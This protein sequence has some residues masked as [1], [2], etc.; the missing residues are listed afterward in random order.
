M[1]HLEAELDGT[2]QGIMHSATSTSPARALGYTVLASSTSQP[3]PAG[4]LWIQLG[5][6]GSD[7]T[8]I[9]LVRD[10]P[11]WSTSKQSSQVHSREL[12][13]ALLT[14]ARS[15]RFGILC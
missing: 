13:T 14:L 4:N 2:L 12:C 3:V 8:R 5:E 7:P 15:L 11:P 9:L 10:K 6:E 1:E